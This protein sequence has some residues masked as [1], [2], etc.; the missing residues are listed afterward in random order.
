MH[1]FVE[2]AHLL[3]YLIPWAYME[4]IGVGKLD[5][6]LQID[7]ILGG[8]GALDGALGAHV[9]KDGGLDGAVGAGEFAPTGSIVDFF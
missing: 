7:Q 9:H 1:K 3:D 6:A 5:L 2:A 8:E 4:M